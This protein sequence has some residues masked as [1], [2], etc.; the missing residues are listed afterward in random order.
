VSEKIIGARQ[1]LQCTA[2]S[3]YVMTTFIARRKPV[4][5]AGDLYRTVQ[6]GAPERRR[7]TPQPLHS[8]QTLKHCY[9]WCTSALHFSRLPL[10]N[11]KQSP[12]KWLKELEDV[13]IASVVSCDQ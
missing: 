13:G 6:I 1:P 3:I 5:S 2:Q 12:G 9:C 10:C 11:L 4:A 7:A 8:G